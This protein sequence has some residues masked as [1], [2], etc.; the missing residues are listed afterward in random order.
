MREAGERR[1]DASPVGSTAGEAASSRGRGVGA[2]PEASAALGIQVPVPQA[3]E[4]Q[5]C[6]KLIITCIFLCVQ[7]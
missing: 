2:S 5:I 6:T 3:A 4:I 7:I 1:L